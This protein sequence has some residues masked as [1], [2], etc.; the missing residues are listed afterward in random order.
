[1]NGRRV[2]PATAAE[3]LPFSAARNFPMK[4]SN[5]FCKAR[6]TTAF[7][8]AWAKA[9]ARCTRA[10]ASAI[11]NKS[12]MVH[13][14]PSD[15]FKNKGPTKQQFS[16]FRRLRGGTGRTRTNHQNVMEHGGVRPAPPRSYRVS[17]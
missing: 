6:E 4:P 11:R 5:S 13:L 9:G 2:M 1:M 12:F 14:R 3:S 10:A 16:G 15:Q 8:G 17:G 7:F